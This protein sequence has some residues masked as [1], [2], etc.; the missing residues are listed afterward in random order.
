MKSPSLRLFLLTAAL[1]LVAG[2]ESD[3]DYGGGDVNFY[4]SVGYSSFYD[5][6]YGGYYGG[7]GG[8]IVSPPINRPPH[9]A[10][11]PAARPRR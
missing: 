9:P 6:W 1:A 4:G 7:G 3:D 10:H 8:I 11:L 2:C 5:P